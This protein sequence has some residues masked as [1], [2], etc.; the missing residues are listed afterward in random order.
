MISTKQNKPKE[1][2]KENLAECKAAG[3]T[4]GMHSKETVQGNCTDQT[5][6]TASLNQAGSSHHLIRVAFLSSNSP[7]LYTFCTQTTTNSDTCSTS[8]CSLLAFLRSAYHHHKSCHFSPTARE[9]SSQV[10][11]QVVKAQ[12]SFRFLQVSIQSS[13][14]C[15]TGSEMFIYPMLPL[16]SLK[17]KTEWKL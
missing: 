16:N 6:D 9:T 11:T 3:Q 8:A 12:A 17:I 14:H 13:K 15:Y 10:T 1:K 2:R 5:Q 4:P 7:S